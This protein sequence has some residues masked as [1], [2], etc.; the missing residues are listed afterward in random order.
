MF[1]THSYITD[2]SYILK[3]VYRQKS[4][5]TVLVPVDK[6]SSYI[7]RIVIVYSLLQIANIIIIL[8]PRNGP[9]S[10]IN[11][12]IPEGVKNVQPQVRFLYG[13]PDRA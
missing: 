3:I 9:L 10:E 13:N 1:I 2:N 11:Q 12:V 7:L 8:K 5:N 6:T 4:P